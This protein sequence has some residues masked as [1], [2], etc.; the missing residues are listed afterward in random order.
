MTSSN[1]PQQHS[2]RNNASDE[3]SA[4]DN[5]VDA[6]S[7]VSYGSSSETA[8]LLDEIDSLLEDDAED[9]VRS[10]VQKGGQ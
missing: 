8:D 5:F 4:V 10:F 9:Y 2:S 6:P 3:V 7:G 1:Q